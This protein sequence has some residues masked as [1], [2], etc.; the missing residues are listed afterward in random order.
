MKKSKTIYQASLS[1]ISIYILLF[2]TGCNIINLNKAEPEK[3]FFSF[4]ELRSTALSE[5]DQKLF[6]NIMLLDFTSMSDYKGSQFIYKSR[7]HYI[8]DY[9]NRF[10]FP[11][12]KMIKNQCAQWFNSTKSKVSFSDLVLKGE[13]LEIYCDRT[14]NNSPL[15][16][17]SIRF[18][19][20]EYNKTDRTIIKKDISS[21]VKFK[22]F[23]PD[24]LVTAWTTCLENIFTDLETEILSVI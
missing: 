11:P 14:T 18:S 23:T 17:I 15:A 24:N 7:N 6:S 10:F 9:Y 8:K 2:F 1:L 4:G 16:K 19:L 20:I 5:K 3:T 22:S 12:E 21:G 13:I